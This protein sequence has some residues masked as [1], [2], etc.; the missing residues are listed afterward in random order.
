M[1]ECQRCGDASPVVLQVELADFV[2]EAPKAPP[3][4]QLRQLLPCHLHVVRHVQAHHFDART[5]CETLSEFGTRVGSISATTSARHLG[6]WLQAHLTAGRECTHAH[7]R[8]RCQLRLG[9][10][11]CWPLLQG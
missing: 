3:A 6:S 11:R 9:R 7:C 1:P 5:A 2:E 8:R 10:R 4:L